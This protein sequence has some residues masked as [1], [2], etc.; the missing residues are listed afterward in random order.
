MTFGEK[1]QKCRKEAGLSQ[2]EL[3]EQLDVSR[4]AVS[5]W[6]RDSGYPETEKLIRMSRLFRVT[7]DYLLLEEVREEAGCAPEGPDAQSTPDQGF[8][9]SRELAEGYLSHQRRRLMKLGGGWGLL[10]GSLSLSFWSAHLGSVLDTVLM[11]TAVLLLVSVKLTGDPYRELYRQPLVFDETVRQEFTA[12]WDR[13]KSWTH[14]LA[15]LGMALMAVGILVFPLL[16]LHP[17]SRADILMAA[18]FVLA[19]IGTFLC[20]YMIGIFRAFRVLLGS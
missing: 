16:D 6:E 12:A 10:V 17:Q 13:T 20:V 8:Y 9:V 18:G 1:L 7:L 5:K 14:G 19:G 2:E 11:I 15:L 4:Q 3:A